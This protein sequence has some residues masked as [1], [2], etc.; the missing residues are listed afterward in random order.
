MKKLLLFVLV[1]SFLNSSGQTGS[2]IYLFDLKITNGQVVVSNGRNITNHK[3][4]DN[5]PFFHPLQPVIYYSSFD[6]SGRSDIK[7][8][9]YERKETKNLTLT[10]E[11]EYSPTVTPDGQFISCIIQRDN[12]AQDLGKY[13]ISSGKPE[14]LINHLKIGYHAWAGENRLLLFVLDDSIHNSLHYYYLG[15]NA[16]T[17]IAENIGRSLHK[18]PGQNAMSFVQ[19]VSEKLSIIKKFDMSTGIISD[20]IPTLPGQDHF[21]WLQ[22]DMLLMSDGNK[23]FTCRDKLDSIWQP[24]IIKGDTAMLKGITRLAINTDNTKLAVVVSE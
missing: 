13:P 15:K 8:Y 7:Y 22:D 6:D 12:G 11:R 21:T 10:H 3:G 20:I 18:I 5:Q 2:E 19:K 17:V 1:F 9:N 14:V 4:Y 16:D 23:L 24:V